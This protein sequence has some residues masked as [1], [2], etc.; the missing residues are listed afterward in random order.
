MAS[1]F[2][3]I[4]LG[5]T[6]LRWSIY[7][8][9]FATST[10]LQNFKMPSTNSCLVLGFTSL[11]INSFSSCHKFSIGFMSGDSAGVFH[12]LIPFSS[13]KCLARIEVCLGSLSCMNLWWLGNFISKN[14]KR[15]PR[16]ISTNSG[17]FM[18]PSNTHIPVAPF[19]LIPAQTWT[20]TGCL[21]LQKN[22]TV[23][24]LFGGAF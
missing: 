2:S 11:Q 14:G 20:L 7:L 19:L 21:A 1:P 12:Q 9:H 16:M 10:V 15:V 18:M 13:K 6:F 23:I 17:A 24:I 22:K 4:T 3:S 5:M 8:L